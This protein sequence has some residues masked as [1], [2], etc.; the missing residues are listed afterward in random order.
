M[1]REMKV[2]NCFAL[3]GCA[4]LV[5]LLALPVQQG[6]LPG[7]LAGDTRYSSIDFETQVHAVD[8]KYVFA[9]K[10]HFSFTF[11]IVISE[12]KMK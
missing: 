6:G 11:N 12:S 4:V 9:S 7:G 3:L 10:A 2:Y 1:E 8:R 5:S